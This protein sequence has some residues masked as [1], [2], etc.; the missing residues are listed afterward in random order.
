[1]KIQI[2]FEKEL[3][4]TV[5]DAIDTKVTALGKL[6]D[7]CLKAKQMDAAGQI[8]VDIKALHEIRDRIMD[9]VNPPTPKSVK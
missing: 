9:Q 8:N 4:Q 6:V 7:N 2:Q 1:M 3:S 5:I